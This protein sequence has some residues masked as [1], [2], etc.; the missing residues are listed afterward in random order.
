MDYL[1]TPPVWSEIK[2]TVP[3]DVAI[4][5][6]LAAEAAE[7]IS[8]QSSRA[9]EAVLV[10]SELA[11]NHLAH[12]T[13]NGLI[14]ISGLILK[15]AP[16]LTIAS[17]DEG[18]GIFDV[19]EAVKDGFSTSGGLGI[20]L[21]TVMRLSDKFH[22]CS[23]KVGTSPC[24][25][26]GSDV[27]FDTVAVSTLI[28]RKTDIRG[29]EACPLEEQNDSL[30]RQPQR[31]NGPDISALIR[32][33]PGEICSGDAFHCRNDERFCRM[34]LIDATGHGVSAANVSQRI[35][36]TMSGLSLDMEP[37][38]ILETAGDILAGSDGASVHVLLIDRVLSKIK[39]AGI[40]NVN[41]TL[42]LDGKR[43]KLISR[44][45]VLGNG[46][47]VL[48]KSEPYDFSSHIL[49]FIHSDGVK[50]PPDLAPEIALKPVPSD[51]WAQL[52]FSPEPS[53]E[54]DASLVVFKWWRTKR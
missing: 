10:A 9:K 8:F 47:S 19:K 38:K 54:D 48:K 6:R 12:N 4:A 7:R 39:A 36:D 35:M 52:F 5:R 24:P 1:K 42:Y 20:G 11:Q 25:D 30:A 45:G 34:T 43:H 18:P 15:D 53:I 28:D 33:Y 50:P 17:L 13:R 27:Q 3:G 31:N 26:L 21:G 29:A 16:Q 22:I 32:P 37:D 49:C 51:I 44:P 23:M 41:G 46:R 40:G 2:I 14:R